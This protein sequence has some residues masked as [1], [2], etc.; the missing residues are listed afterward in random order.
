MA[1]NVSAVVLLLI[2]VVYLVRKSGLKYSHAVA[3]VLLG[4]YL[5]SSSVA[6]SIQKGASNVANMISQIHL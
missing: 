3:C 1:V 2:V 6:P 4:F 5:A